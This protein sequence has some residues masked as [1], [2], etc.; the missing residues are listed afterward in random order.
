[1][2]R[3]P[4][5]ILMAATLALGGCAGYTLGPTNGMAA[6][7]R[8]VAIKPFVNRTNEPRVTE[9]VAMSLRRELQTDGTFH[10]DT[11][12]TADILISGEI[13]HFQRL[14]LAY[15][16]NDVLTPESY[17]LLLSA[18]VV[19]RN[20]DSGRTILDQEVTGRTYMRVGSDL[21]SSER[22]AMPILADE[23]ARNAINLLADGKW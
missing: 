16:T 17:T 22:E 3:A 7:A 18:H 4:I 8:T 6:G 15:S 19:A 13:T 14:A 23:L 2:R 12:G 5:W 11:S 9:Y 20:A 21:G 10:L 1:M